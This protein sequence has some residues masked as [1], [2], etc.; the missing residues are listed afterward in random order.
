MFPSTKKV[1]LGDVEVL[2]MDLTYGYMIGIEDGTVEDTPI[3]A[4]L[5]ATEFTSIDDLKPFRG[6]EIEIL[7]QT[8]LRLTYPQAYNDDGTIK[9]LP[10]VEEDS[11]KKA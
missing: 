3:N 8:I 11:K 7:L 5:D 1:Q 4:V 6:S 10:N 2:C 9:E